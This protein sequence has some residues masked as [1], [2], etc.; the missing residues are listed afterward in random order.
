M[1]QWNHSNPT[2]NFSQYVN[3]DYSEIKMEMI[4]PIIVELWKSYIEMF[5]WSVERIISTY[6]RLDYSVKDIAEFEYVETGKPCWRTS[7]LYKETVTKAMIIE[8]V[9]RNR[10][11]EHWIWVDQYLIENQYANVAA[12]EVLKALM[13]EDYPWMNEGVFVK[14]ITDTNFWHLDNLV[15]VGEI[16]ELQEMT[17]GCVRRMSIDDWNKMLAKYIDRLPKLKES[18]FKFYFD[19]CREPS[20]FLE[21][22]G[23]ISYYIPFEAFLKKDWDMFVKRDYGVNKSFLIRFSDEEMKVRKSNPIINSFK[24]HMLGENKD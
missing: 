24:E 23:E 21:Y 16:P 15:K 22:G 6:E 14:E 4:R 1:K 17:I 7:V 20:F 13:F 19:N 9:S 10:K 11:F 8:R 5:G 12:K 2:S 3:E 18:R